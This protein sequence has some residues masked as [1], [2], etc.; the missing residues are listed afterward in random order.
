[1]SSLYIKSYFAWSHLINPTRCSEILVRDVDACAMKYSTPV[2]YSR[3]YRV[4]RFKMWYMNRF[5][6][7]YQISGGSVESVCSG[8]EI[9]E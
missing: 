9:L 3:A 7:W 4:G 1:M 2:E 8:W 6:K 5:G